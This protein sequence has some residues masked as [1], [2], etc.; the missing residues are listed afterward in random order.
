[1]HY[2]CGRH[3]ISIISSGCLRRPIRR[4]LRSNRVSVSQKQNL[5][6][7]RPSPYS[8]TCEGPADAAGSLAAGSPATTEASTLVGAAAGMGSSPAQDGI[9]VT[10]GPSPTSDGGASSPPV[11]S[12]AL[13]ASGSVLSR[14]PGLRPLHHA[15]STEITH[16][17]NN[18]T[19]IHIYPHIQSQIYTYT[20]T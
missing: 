5:T 16:S 17:F 14:S 6:P 20:F 10:K 2:G 19:N 18:H 15:P 1:M 7:D 11:P 9:G 8:A 3:K 12:F 4:N 13:D